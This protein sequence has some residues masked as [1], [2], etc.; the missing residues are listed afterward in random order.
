MKYQEIVS[1]YEACLEKHGDN[2]LGVDWPRKEDVIKRYRIMLELVRGTIDKPTVLDFG[3]GAAHLYDYLIKQD[4]IEIDYSGLDISEKFVLLCRKKH[5]KTQFYCVDILSKDSSIP[6]TD[7]IVMNG[8]FTEKQSMTQEE[9]IEYFQSMLKKIFPLAK[10][11]IAFN[12]MSRYVDW[13]RS[14]LFHIS[15]DEMASFVTQHLSRH[16]VIRNDYGLY[17]YTVYIYH[18]PLEVN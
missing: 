10:K 17:E 9:M 5:P 15:L 13:E 1:H 11:G 14:D 18:E 16:F 3:C 4:N 2:H 6:E 7:Y 8:V 12:V